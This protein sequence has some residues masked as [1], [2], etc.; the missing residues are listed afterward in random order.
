MPT[1]NIFQ[2]ACV[3]VTAD[4]QNYSGRLDS[5]VT[6]DVQWPD[7]HTSQSQ[8]TRL[9]IKIVLSRYVIMASGCAMC[10]HMLLAC[11]HVQHA[12]HMLAYHIVHIP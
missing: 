1:G 8:R 6:C 9:T 3:Q 12:M 11:W 2:N 10:S 5:P 7:A 4:C